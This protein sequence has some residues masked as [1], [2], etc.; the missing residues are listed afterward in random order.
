MH[1]ALHLGVQKA[2]GVV[3]SHY[4]VDL[5]AISTGYVVPIG[6][7]VEVAINRAD[8][9]AAP[10]ADILAEDFTNFLFP[11]APAAGDPQA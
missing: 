11:D 10:A 8:A 6:I 2:L 3:A 1:R 4:Q 5:E 7:Y 9:L